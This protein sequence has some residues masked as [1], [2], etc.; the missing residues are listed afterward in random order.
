[1]TI[2]ANLLWRTPVY[3]DHLLHFTNP[4]GYSFHVINPSYKD[5]LCIR[6]T[7]CWSLERSLYTSFTVRI[8]HI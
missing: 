5:Q 2:Q 3:K 7:F 8:Y 4:Q 1:M 6:I